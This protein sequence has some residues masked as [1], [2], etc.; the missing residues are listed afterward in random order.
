MG[1][2]NDELAATDF[3]ECVNGVAN[4]I[5]EG[6]KDLVCVAQNRG[7][8]VVRVSFDFDALIP[9]VQV[10][11]VQGAGN[12]GVEVEFGFFG[13]H[14]T[15]ETQEARDVSF[16]AAGQR[17]NLVGDSAGTFGEARIVRKQI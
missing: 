3:F 16:D 8:F 4:D 13:G 2:P 10:R 5:E 12:N 9:Q 6:L 1:R 17:A 15:G 11:E 7:E 14:A